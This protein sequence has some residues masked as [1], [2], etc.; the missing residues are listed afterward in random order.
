MKAKEIL[1]VFT[2]FSCPIFGLQWTPPQYESDVARELIVFLEDRRVLYAPEEDEG[3]DHC[4]QSVELIREEVTKA[5]QKVS[6]NSDIA[7]HLRR[8]RKQCRT[9]CDTVGAPNYTTQPNPV[10]TSILKTQLEALRSE[11]GKVVGSLS[12][13]YG[14]DVEDELATTIP[15]SPTE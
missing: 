8:L 1:K 12:V 2:G 13:A 9:F 3:A 10:Q 15:F 5:L 6:F 7:K 14:L 4:R 11:A